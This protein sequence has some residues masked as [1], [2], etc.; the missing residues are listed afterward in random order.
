MNRRCVLIDQEETPT[1]MGYFGCGLGNDIHTIQE[2]EGLPEQDKRK[3]LKF[4][5]GD[6]VMLVGGSPFKYLK[7]YYHF[8]VRGE[9]YYDCSLL[10]RLSIEGGAFVKCVDEFP[11]N[12]IIADFM[13][14][15]FT[16]PVVYSNF[17]YKII[18]TLDEAL[19]FIDYMD[20]L[21][22]DQNYGFDYEASGMPLD[23][24]FWV[25]GA[26]LVT[27]TVGAFV[28]FTDIRHEVG[29]ENTPG[30]KKLCKRLGDFLFKRMNFVWTYNMQYEW[31]VSH[32]VLGVDLYN[33][34]DASAVN[35]MDGYHMK[36]Y[37]L[38]WTAQ[39]VLQVNV[40][41]SDFDRIDE[42]ID[43]ALYKI[44]GKLK[45]EQH[46]V[47][48]VDQNTFYKTPEW[49]E[50]SKR[51]PQYIGEFGRLLIEYWGYP[52]MCVPSDILGKYC[53]LD[54]LHTLLIAKSRFG[55][56]SKDCWNVNL[57][58]I[59]LGARLMGSGLY[60]DEPYRL[61]YEHYCHEQMAWSITYCAMARCWMKME[62]HKSLAANPKRY[63]P[64]AIILLER[65]KFFGG[66]AIEITKYLLLSNLDILDAY[67]TGLN[68]GQILLTY[69]PKFAN[70]FVQLVKDS[71]TSTKF[72]GKIDSSVGRKK[73]ILGVIAEGLK[74]L[75]GLD[76]LSLGKK[77]IELE[78]YMWYKTAYTELS[79]VASRQ[80]TDIYNV[81]EQIHAFGQV[82]SQLD[83]AN[84]VSDNFFKCKSPIENDEIAFDYSSLHKMESCY[85]AAMLESTQQLKD[86]THF[87]EAR[88]IK[89]IE[90]GFND[91]VGQWKAYVY[92][93]NHTGKYDYPDKVFN[94]ALEFWQSMKKI[95]TMS[96]KVKDVWTNFNG[97]TAQY[98][99]FGYTKDQY[100]EYEK[101]FDPGDMS[102][103][104]FFMRKFT[105]NYLVYKKYAKL[106]S[107]Y[108]GDSG[109]FHKT[110]KWIIEGQ[111]HIP[112]R[113]ADS[114]EPGAVWKVFVHYEVMTKSSKRWSSP[115][116][117]II[118]HGKNLIAV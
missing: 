88:G 10:R 52:F 85:L 83:Y 64:E 60:I 11:G 101:H 111:D 62:K 73:K 17:K 86:M 43:S 29:G 74:P 20:S 91:F 41:D 87:Y 34:C 78:K 117:T 56:Y 76:K 47:F 70:A 71:M 54:S 103:K 108:V 9:N 14:P 49:Q 59:R 109:M 113:E 28:S 1:Y 4:G 75:L 102:N 112:L 67:D 50:L 92:D 65:G 3:I 77:H 99:F 58:N 13:S 110:G 93:K 8:G 63:K 68:E 35:T 33:L 46:K 80:L 96:D 53:C 81:P 36:K 90:D 6:A 106:E 48:K 69:G 55:T 94:L 38:K 57:D 25:S 105:L 40:W 100:E 37:S 19:K 95:D 22:E 15:D 39:R 79:K 66:N 84:Y 21:P 51:Y 16:K 23:R 44:E 116:H 98:Q 89:T 24:Y 32:R 61:R 27:E 72:K 5:P 30:Y 114:N 2:L 104:F 115:F 107:T 31:Q 97:L 12:D 7:Q 18:H 42:L 26:S 118:S 45:R 82:F